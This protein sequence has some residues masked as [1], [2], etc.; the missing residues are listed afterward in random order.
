MDEQKNPED[1]HGTV[2]FAR[3]LLSSEVK[4]LQSTTF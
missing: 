3:D 2:N 1:L 4:E